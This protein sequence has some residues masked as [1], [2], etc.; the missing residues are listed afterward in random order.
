VTVAAGTTSATFPVTTAAVPSSTAVTITGSA[1]GTSRSATLTVT[2]NL[3]GFRGPTAN[4]ADSGG[5][6]NG[7]ES[8]AVNAHTDDAANAVDTNS[9]T[10]STSSCTSTARDRH[11]F[12][13][14]GLGVPAGASVLGLEIRLDAR[15]DGTNGAPK[16]C[17]ELSW[18]GGVTWTTP[19]S[20]PTLTTS[21][22]TY[23]LGGAADTWGRPW[24]P[25]ELSDASFR[26]RVTDVA[27]STARDF[28]LD[29]I[30]VRV[31]T[32]G[33][34][35]DTT[36]PAVSIG[37]PAAGTTVSGTT[38]ISANASDNAGV[39]RVEFLVDGTL[40]GTDTTSPYSASWNTTTATN[41]AHSLTARAFDAAGNQATSAAVG[42]T[43]SNGSA[44]V[45]DLTLSGV[46]ASIR[47]GQFF[48]A[49]GRVA[50]TGGASA[51]GYT[52]LVTFTPADSMRLESPQG[53]SQ[54]LATV[55]AGGT[56]SVSWQIR[57]DR[58]ASATLTMTLRSSSGATVDT[59]SHAIT[60]TD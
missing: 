9:G 33:G 21:M 41:G 27:S 20:T 17:V 36:P 28:S 3:A 10:A 56:Q 5:D 24:T 38:T 43:V 50:N 31:T 19:R 30:A 1:G 55:A 47:R 2:P 26:V 54:S 6:G 58:A 8:G 25:A 13:N 40:L 7:F 34:T 12:F 11:R 16:M 60:I 35:A 44:P 22:A 49:T 23:V 39:A 51:S 57:A 15:A 14:Y 4:A 53:S 48:T 18:D 37:A 32:G 42:V 46:P 29:W 45:L 52:V 59:A